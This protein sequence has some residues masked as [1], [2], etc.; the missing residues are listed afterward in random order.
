LVDI[1]D[2]GPGVERAWEKLTARSPD[3]VCR[4][5]GAT[6][7]RDTGH[8]A[9]QCFGVRYVV[10]PVGRSIVPTD[11][12]SDTI[13]EKVSYF[14]V[15]SVVWYMGHAVDLPETGRLLNMAG[16]KGGAN[17]FTGAHT[18]PIADLATLY[19]DSR[20]ALTEKALSPGGRKAGY[21][22]ESVT[23]HPLPGISA[24]LILWYGDDEF[25]PRADLLFDSSIEIR[26]P[27]DVIWSIAMMTV[28]AFL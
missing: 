14:F 9:I 6:H 16:L 26:L 19:N 5:T 28:L 10:D 21:G 12:T 27:L 2:P 8:Y 11:S 20:G 17:F 13:R 3:E 15:H 22:D 1:G 18:L 24:T 23:L 7:D 4:G 25:G